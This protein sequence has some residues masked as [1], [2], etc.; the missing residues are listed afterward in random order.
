VESLECLFCQKTYP[1]NLFYPF[2]PDCHEPLL[3]HYPPSKRAVHREKERPLER[4]SEFLPQLELRPELSLGEGNTPLIRLERT[5]RK[6]ELPFLCAKNEASNPTSSFKDRGSVV[7]VHKALSLGIDRIGTVSTGNMANSTAAYGAKA[8]LKT[9]V[10]V[11]EDISRAKLTATAVHNPILISV[12]GDYGELFRK[13]FSIGQKYRIYFM[14]SVDPMRLE[15]YKVPG[16]EIFAQ[17][18]GHVPDYVFVPVSSGGHLIGLM[19]GFQDLKAAGLSQTLPVFIG[20]QARGCSPIAQAFALEKTRVERIDKPQT[21]AH[22]ISNPDP[23]GGNILLKMMK[24]SKGMVIDVSDQKI[25]KAQRILAELEGLFCMPASATTLAGLMKLSE[26]I[27][28]RPSDQIVLM[29][30]GSGVKALDALASSKINV[31][32][33]ALPDLEDRIKFF[34]S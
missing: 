7:A 27:N 16:Y 22:A 11:K 25:L 20:V 28:F 10:L 15:G 3:F 21:I 32:P 4:Y 8:G 17:L 18:G 23:P 14:N 24:E 6:F 12:K 34:I 30:T 29:I 13:S 26:K 19:K 33:T 5:R 1:L 31:W 9:F 2:C